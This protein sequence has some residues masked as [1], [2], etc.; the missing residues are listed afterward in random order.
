MV[1]ALALFFERV[2][3][4]GEFLGTLALVLPGW[5]VGADE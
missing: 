5:L 3:A 4:S 1:E 2:S